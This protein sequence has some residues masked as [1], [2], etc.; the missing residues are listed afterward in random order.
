[1][2]L[3]VNN[4]TF[5]YGRGHG[6]VLDGVSFSA[7]S[8]QTI[9][10][11]GHNGAGKSTLF[12]CLLGLSD[13]YGGSVRIDGR[14]LS[15]LT[16]REVSRAMAYIPQ[17][18]DPAFDY[19]VIDIVLMGRA[20]HSAT[21]ATGSDEDEQIAFKALDRLGIAHLANCGYA[22]ISGGERQLV[23]IARALAQRTQALV[24]D[25]PTANLDYGNQYR[26]M[27]LIESLREQGYLVIM[28]THNPQ[29]AL[30]FATQV[31]VLHE[32]HLIACGPPSDVMTDALLER[33]YSIPVHVSQ[34][35]S[36]S[37]VSRQV[38]VP[39]D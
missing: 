7:T 2:Q 31:L 20:V 25:E 32:G 12:R 13:G 14:E 35:T 5:S 4:L 27:E 10:L 21:G 9:C 11:L 34:A 17:S 16:R 19:A 8:G 26:T 33:I 3:E 6:N 36:A 28:S 1:M 23:L 37:G 24:M 22:H 30:S 38:C 15:Q 29:Q 18:S 39:G